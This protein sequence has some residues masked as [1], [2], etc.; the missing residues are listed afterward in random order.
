M[1]CLV[2]DDEFLIGLDIQQVLESAGA[3]S[4][5]CAGSASDALAA[6]GSGQ[7]FNVA[8]LDVRLRGTAETSMAV[9]AAL[10]AQGT[11]FVFLTGMRGEDV[12]TRQ[13]P[14]A[15]VIE[16][17]YQEPLLIDAV[18]RALGLGRDRG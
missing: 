11:A 6:L 7:K 12:H 2:L 15:P 10:A 3:A 4:V 13:F 1:H 14:D 16:K 18:L 17:P 5:V 8:V 9:A